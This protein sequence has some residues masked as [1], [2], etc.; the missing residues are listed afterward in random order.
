MASMYLKNTSPLI[1]P[2]A[3]YVRPSDWALISDTLSLHHLLKSWIPLNKDSTNSFHASNILITRQ[4]LISLAIVVRNHIFLN[5]R[6]FA[7]ITLT[8]HESGEVFNYIED[9]DEMRFF[10]ILNYGMEGILIWSYR[11]PSCTDI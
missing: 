1:T 8:R 6:Y 5:L 3:Y 2:L 9:E 7:E 10:C 4:T 11:I